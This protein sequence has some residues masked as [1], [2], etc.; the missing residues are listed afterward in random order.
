MFLTYVFIRAESFPKYIFHT[1]P[2][3]HEKY[4]LTALG[5]QCWLFPDFPR[6]KSP[7]IQCQRY[8]KDTPSSGYPPPPYSRSARDIP[9]QPGVVQCRRGPLPP[10]FS[11]TVST[12]SR[13]NEEK[14]G[15]G[16]FGQAQRPLHRHGSASLV[17]ER[18]P[19]N[20]RIRR[21]ARN[22]SRDPRQKIIPGKRIAYPRTI[23]R[24]QLRHRK[25]ELALDSP[26]GS[27]YP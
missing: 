1:K 11:R 20:A 13:A 12:D 7:S 2:N 3:S 27:P 5:S 22:V 14:S 9:G 16:R 21:F 26:W 24:V 17:S 8:G 6:Q 23:A 19:G 4:L 25:G 18:I 15:S 10:A